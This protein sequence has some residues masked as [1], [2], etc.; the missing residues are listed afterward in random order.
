M[1][2]A[3]TSFHRPVRNDATGAGLTLGAL[4]AEGAYADGGGPRVLAAV[5]LGNCNGRVCGI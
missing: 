4:Y 2:V 3:G 1:G 5:R